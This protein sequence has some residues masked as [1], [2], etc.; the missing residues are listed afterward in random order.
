MGG[1][2]GTLGAWTPLQCMCSSKRDGYGVH[3][4][5]V[6]DHIAHPTPCVQEGENDQGVLNVPRIEEGRIEELAGL[7]GAQQRKRARTT[8]TAIEEQL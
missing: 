5:A 2:G 7:E 1:V 8:A 6:C 4:M 3:V